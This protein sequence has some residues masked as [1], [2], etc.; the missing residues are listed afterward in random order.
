M[1]RYR[2]L[3]VV[4]STTL[5]S[6]ALHSN[7]SFDIFTDGNIEV[8]L[9]SRSL[10]DILLDYFSSLQFEKLPILGMRLYRGFSDLV[11]WVLTYDDLTI[12]S[13]KL[14]LQAALVLAF[15]H[16][17]VLPG[18]QGSSS[19]SVARSLTRKHATAGSTG[20]TVIS[21]PAINA[22]T[23]QLK[24][25]VVVILSMV[26]TLVVTLVLGASAAVP[27]CLTTGKLCNTISISTL[28]TLFFSSLCVC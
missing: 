6:I 13:S 14:C 25:L 1:W 12:V 23:S 3:I 19:S 20:S 11:K 18:L 21:V 5:L 17:L 2:Q 24:I 22:V 28:L 16:G 10:R 15:L 27:M 9:V 8:L 7:N 4:S 26:L